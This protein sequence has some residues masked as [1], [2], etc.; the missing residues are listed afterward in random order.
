MDDFPVCH[1][2]PASTGLTGAQ[3]PA[4]NLPSRRSPGTQGQS[5]VN[6]GSHFPCTDQISVGVLLS[7]PS[8]R[9][10]HVRQSAPESLIPPSVFSTDGLDSRLRRTPNDGEN[11]IDAATLQPSLPSH[12]QEQPRHVDARN[13]GRGRG[14]RKQAGVVVL[15]T[16]DDQ[17]RIELLPQH[18]QSLVCYY[19]GSAAEDQ[20]KA[21]DFI[22]R[23]RL[24]VPPVEICYV[25][26][27]EGSPTGMIQSVTCQLCPSDSE[28]IYFRT[29]NPLPAFAGHFRKFHL[30][31]KK[32]FSCPVPS[33]GNKFNHSHDVSRHMKA[34]HPV[35]GSSPSTSRTS[36]RKQYE[37]TAGYTKG[38]NF[39]STS[40]SNIAGPSHRSSPQNARRA[41]PPNRPSSRRPGPTTTSLRTLER[42]SD[43]RSGDTAHPM[44]VVSPQHVPPPSQQ[45]QPVRHS[46]GMSELPQIT[47]SALL[48][49]QGQGPIG[50]PY[51]A[52]PSPLGNA[53]YD[54]ALRQPPLARTYPSSQ[55]QNFDDV[56]LTAR[57]WMPG[58]IGLNSDG[59]PLESDLSPQMSQSISPLQGDAVLGA[60]LYEIPPQPIDQGGNAMAPATSPPWFPAQLARNYVPTQPSV[61][62]PDVGRGQVQQ[63]RSGNMADDYLSQAQESGR[64]YVGMDNAAHSM[65]YQHVASS[66]LPQHNGQTT[67]SPLHHPRQPGA[68]QQSPT[69]L[70]NQSNRAPLYDPS[71]IPRGWERPPTTSNYMHFGLSGPTHNRGHCSM[72]S[73]GQGDHIK[74]N[75]RDGG[76]KVSPDGKLL[77]GEVARNLA[78]KLPLWLDLIGHMVNIS[79]A[80]LQRIVVRLGSPWVR[81]ICGPSFLPVKDEAHHIWT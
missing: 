65:T 10:Q 20:V 73:Y 24:L 8:Q 50:A 30:G 25:T 21:L 57:R 46:A 12:E 15:H 7:I 62:F 3:V 22:Y 9:P 11:E 74:E 70:Q 67:V 37:D 33:C 35:D 43:T 16:Q 60:F 58:S 71:G 68:I 34:A 72:D 41:I 29:P 54:M 31:I 66:Y 40:V 19:V 14:G 55:Y 49:R 2:M 75:P 81:K 23:Y 76:D 27:K 6:T 36:R 38:D 59:P 48:T 51:D 78:R 69:P 47:T 79:R 1:D 61:S 42:V 77:E 17:Q 44:S 4:P 52:A 53:G 13:L 28:G 56:L 18:L 5:T 26:R 80:F 63:L 39:S 64:G 32:S 45:R